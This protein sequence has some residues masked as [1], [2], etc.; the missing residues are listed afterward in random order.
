MILRLLLIVAAFVI[1]ASFLKGLSPSHAAQAK[2]RRQAWATA[3][4]Q[5][6]FTLAAVIFGGVTA[7][8]TWHALRFDD[9]SAL[10]LGAVTGPLTLL[11]GFLAWR[12]SRQ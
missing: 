5:T 10:L 8:A 11:L 4:R 12:A 9:H 3:V 7:F 1:I 2:R 6:A